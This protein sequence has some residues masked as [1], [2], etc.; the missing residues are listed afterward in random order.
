MTKHEKKYEAKDLR[1]TKDWKGTW[2]MRKKEAKVYPILVP[3]LMK[4]WQFFDIDSQD[5][6]ELCELIFKHF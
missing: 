6:F 3:Y 2:D 5:D 1:T 4:D